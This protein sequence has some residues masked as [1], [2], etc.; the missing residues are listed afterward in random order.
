MTRWRLYEMSV[1]AVGRDGGRDGPGRTGRLCPL[2]S[3]DRGDQE[4]NA[5]I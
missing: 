1:L 3:V 2:L 5:E 4:V